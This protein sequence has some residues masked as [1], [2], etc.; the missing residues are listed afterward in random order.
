[1]FDKNTYEIS[2]LDR[3][4]QTLALGNLEVE[5]LILSRLDKVLHCSFIYEDRLSTSVYQDENV[6]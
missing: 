6:E 4:E 1:M 5:V 2:W 3:V